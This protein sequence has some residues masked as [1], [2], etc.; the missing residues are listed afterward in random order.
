MLRESVILLLEIAVGL[1]LL[2]ALR[3]TVECISSEG[4]SVLSS[5]LGIDQYVAKI[6]YKEARKITADRFIIA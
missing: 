5:I 1:E 6:I 3:L 4:P 2:T